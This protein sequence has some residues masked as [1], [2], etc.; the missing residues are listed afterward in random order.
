[1]ISLCKGDS[2]K[3]NADVIVNSVNKLLIGGGG[4]DVASLEGA[5]PGF[6]D[7]CQKLNVCQTGEYNVTLGYKLPAKYM[8]H[9]VK[10]RD[11]NDFELNS[12]YKS[13]LQ[14]VIAYNVKSI[15]FW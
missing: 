6:V 5:G 11:K 13:C 14:K 7:E 12:F 4:I 3:L 15:R 10:H 2:T 8:F 1:M 9:T